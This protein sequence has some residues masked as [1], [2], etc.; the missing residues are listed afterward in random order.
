MQPDKSSWLVIVLRAAGRGFIWVSGQKTKHLGQ[1][2]AISAV[3]ILI[4]NNK[5]IK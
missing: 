4:K 1:Q 5:K 2:A 3:H